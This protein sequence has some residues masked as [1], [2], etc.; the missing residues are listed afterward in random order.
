MSKQQV[1]TLTCSLPFLSCHDRVS[2]SAP[3]SGTDPEEYL[4]AV[5]VSNNKKEKVRD[6]RP[7]RELIMRDFRG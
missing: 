6:S 7:L 3:Q 1:H 2:E 5:M 4:I